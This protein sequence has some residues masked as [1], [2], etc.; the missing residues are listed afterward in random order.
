MA[1]NKQVEVKRLRELHYVW[2]GVILQQFL[3]IAQLQEQILIQ[4]RICR[5]IKLICIHKWSL[6]CELSSISISSIRIPSKNQDF[7]KKS[8]HFNCKQSVLKKIIRSHV[9]NYKSHKPA[10]V[11]PYSGTFVKSL[12]FSFSLFFRWSRA[13]LDTLTIRLII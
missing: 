1:H 6:E 11:L 8:L 5:Y 7:S 10:N 2:V 13:C 3:E 12:S 9:E 4:T